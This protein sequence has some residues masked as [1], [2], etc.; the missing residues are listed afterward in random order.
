M[1]PAPRPQAVAQVL[2]GNAI[3]VSKRQQGNPM[4]KHIRNVRWQFGDIAPDYQ[5][6]QSAAALFL[7]L[8]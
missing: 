2:P 7:S 8:R 3:I 4:L 6:G 5:L 1:A